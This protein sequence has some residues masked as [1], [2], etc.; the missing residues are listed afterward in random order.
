[1][2]SGIEAAIELGAYVGELMSWVLLVI[3]VLLA[4]VIV[5]GGFCLIRLIRDGGGK[6]A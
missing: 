2:F 6:N 1:M 3:A 5:A 4:L